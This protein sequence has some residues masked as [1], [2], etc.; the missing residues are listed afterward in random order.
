MYNIFV[1]EANTNAN[2]YLPGALLEIRVYWWSHS[3]RIQAS[4]SPVAITTEADREIWGMW[5]RHDSNFFF[6]FKNTY[7]NWYKKLQRDSPLT[8]LIQFTE[9]EES[10]SVHMREEWPLRSL[11]PLQSC[12]IPS[13]VSHSR[14][15]RKGRVGRGGRPVAFHVARRWGS[16][17]VVTQW[18]ASLKPIKI[19]N[20]GG[21]EGCK[22]KL[23]WHAYFP[24]AESEAGLKKV[25]I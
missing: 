6:C 22:P 12:F 15:E 21:W 4:F 3:L 1:S 8:T 20:V 14:G 5:H 17:F 7:W 24:V 13:N 10:E 23:P 18:C 16:L 19:P 11:N 9:R 25:A 2:E